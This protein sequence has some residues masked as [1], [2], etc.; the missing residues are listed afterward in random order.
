MTQVQTAEIAE[1]PRVDWDNECDQWITFDLDGNP[2]WDD[3]RQGAITKAIEANNVIMEHL[4]KCPTDEALLAWS[5][6]WT[7]DPVNYKCF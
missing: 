7:D 2:H 6:D 3:N 1:S 5:H 4:A